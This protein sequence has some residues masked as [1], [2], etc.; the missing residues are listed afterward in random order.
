ME[1]KI[2]L[3]ITKEEKKT[4]KQQASEYGL[5]ISEYA[6][7]KLV[8][9]NEDLS[10]ETKYVCPPQAKHNLVVTTTVLKIL[11]LVH[12]LIIRQPDMTSEALTD[13][14]DSTLQ[15]AR[16]IRLEYGYKLLNPE[17]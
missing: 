13:I 17:K 5:S 8:Q 9:E 16:K 2:H 15:F 12:Q 4:L 14:D 11:Y 6:R 1:E 7:R 10:I 3:R